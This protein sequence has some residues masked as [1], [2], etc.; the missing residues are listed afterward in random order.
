MYKVGDVVVI[1]KRE[2][3]AYDYPF[4]FADGMAVLAGQV[5]TITKV[6]ENRILADSLY[7][8]LPTYNN[9]DC[10]YSLDGRAGGYTWHSSM[11]ELA[12]DPKDVISLVE[13]KSLK[14][15]L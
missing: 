10:G 5:Y 1:K 9:D 2:L 3:P 15:L 4:S 13:C 11:F 6:T 12:I 14:V 7:K 8:S